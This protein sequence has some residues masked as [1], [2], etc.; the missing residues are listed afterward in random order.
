M[1]IA[2]SKRI[3]ALVVAALMAVMGLF[4]VQDVWAKEKES[5]KATAK[6]AEKPK[7]VAVNMVIV[8]EQDAEIDL[9][10]EKIQKKKTTPIT[11]TV[12]L[13]KGPNYFTYDKGK[14]GNYKVTVGAYGD[15]SSQTVT[16]VQGAYTLY[17][18]VAPPK[19]GDAKKTKTIV[20]QDL[21]KIKQK[22]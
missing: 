17:F 20:Y 10:V 21:T 15:V 12:T 6:A 14:K 22:K 18:Q 2:K 13:K 1:E 9:S 7:T 3:V 5:T 16:A 11:R 4:A 8:A 19:D